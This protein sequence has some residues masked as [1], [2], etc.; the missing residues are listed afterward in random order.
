MKP[1]APVTRT[2]GLDCCI[3]LIIGRRGTQALYPTT[4][5]C[6]DK[7]GSKRREERAERRPGSE[8]RVAPCR[9]GIR[10]S[11]PVASGHATSSLR[12]AP[13]LSDASGGLT[14][15]EVLVQG[16]DVDHR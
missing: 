2:L 12:C 7:P 13:G 4:H 3:V 10:D 1:A 16:T 6:A 11:A 14:R 8:R 9:A 5:R 15:L